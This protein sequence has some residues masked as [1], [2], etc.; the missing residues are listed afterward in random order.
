[1]AVEKIPIHR[2]LESGKKYP[3]L[4]VRSPA[5]FDHA[6]IPG[7]QNLPLFTDEERK[8]VGT[9]YKQQSREAAIKTGLDYFG[10][11]MRKM[12]EQVENMTTSLSQG[13]DN[14]RILLHCWRGG[15]RSE[16]VAWLL[17]LYGYKVST[18]AG[19]YKSYRKRVLETLTLPFAFNILGGNTGSGKTFVL[20][21]MKKMGAAVIDL[22]ALACHKGSA[23][24]NIGLPAQPS[25]EMFENLLSEELRYYMKSIPGQGE[26]S[27]V[28]LPG[29]QTIWLEDESQRIGHIN[30]P[31]AFWKTMSGSPLLFMVIPFEERLKHIL[32]EYGKLDKEKVADAISR[33]KKRLG[34]LES[35]N[36][37]QFLAENDL[38]SCFHIL[39]KYYD[40]SY[41]KA[42]N[43]RER[44]PV[45]T[46]IECTKVDASLNA[47]K[48]ME[49]ELITK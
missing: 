49:I 41:S 11:R 42:M 32:L 46:H 28:A 16:A 22:E 27:D 48:I 35:K 45:I 6:H 47:K 10:P 5:E 29:K 34:G 13:P 15:M 40:K 1:M 7:A 39:L 25:Q 38:E 4:D 3:V 44:N 24:G 33:I 23:F 43:N 19:G 2:F 8:V 20:E 21:E 14:K 30:I 17:D 26:G 12:V 37:L 31:P 36:A 18:L 9:I